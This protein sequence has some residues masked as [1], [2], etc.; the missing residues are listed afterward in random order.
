MEFNDKEFFSKYFL[1]SANWYFNENLHMPPEQQ[2]DAIGQ[3]KLIIADVIPVSFNNIQI[4]G[5]SALGYS[6]A[7]HKAFAVFGEKSDFDIAL[8][9]P[10]LFSQMW[11][12]FR[13]GFRTKYT[14]IYDYV[15]RSIYRGYINE[16]NLLAIP[17]TRTIWSNCS[18]KVKKRIREE[19]GIPHEVSFRLY[20][21]WSDFE[22]Y[23][24]DSIRKLKREFQ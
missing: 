16:K 23:Q 4:V 24:I 12:A 22:E 8:I 15:I 3:L 10:N 11:A 14:F 9:S 6:L 17:D 7:P 5:S 13:K 19:L 21:D 18:Q 1:R 20:R 2:H